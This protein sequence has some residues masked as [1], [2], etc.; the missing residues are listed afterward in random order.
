MLHSS[1][2]RDC[3][4]IVA[5]NYLSLKRLSFPIVLSRGFVLVINDFLNVRLRFFVSNP[6]ELVLMH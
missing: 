2:K 6:K 1:L 4:K 5:V 3:I